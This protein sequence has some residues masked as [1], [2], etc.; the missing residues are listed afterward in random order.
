MLILFLIFYILA[1]PIPIIEPFT[2]IQINEGS[3]ASFTCYSN[4]SNASVAW[5]RSNGNPLESNVITNNAGQ[6]IFTSAT[7]AN[8]ASYTCSLGNIAGMR[9]L[10]ARLIV[11]GK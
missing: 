3:N 5:S 2:T 8:N 9:T 10:A 1:V 6:I 11:V 7:R 4:S